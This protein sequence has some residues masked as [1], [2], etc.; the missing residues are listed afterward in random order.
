M[1]AICHQTNV[2][3]FNFI[4]LMKRYIGIF[5]VCMSV[6]FAAGGAKGQYYHRI[7]CDISIKSKVENGEGML[8]LGRVFYDKN[9]AKMVYNIR[10]P[11]RE[12]WIVQ[13]T[14][15]HFIKDGKYESATGIDQY[16]QSTIFH[17]ILEGQLQNY[18]LSGTIYQIEGVSREDNMVI[19]TW[20]PR[21][22][23]KVLGNILTSTVDGLLFGVVFKN[24]SND[25][26]GRQLFRNYINVKGLSIPT[27]IVQVY[28]RPD[29]EEYQVHTLSNIIINNPGNENMYNY[30]VV[31][32]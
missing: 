10:F 9:Q 7:E 30:P 15:I 14:T 12:V 6:L 31:P 3:I 26:V 4:W 25:I 32:Q 19:T 28:F 1:P 13:D 8:V 16:N 20:V 2:G 22:E 5:L 29:R 23:N 18:G 27:E 17:K 11:E 21:I 24:A